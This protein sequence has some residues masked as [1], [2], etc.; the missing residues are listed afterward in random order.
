MSEAKRSN[1]NQSNPVT[2]V[3]VSVGPGIFALWNGI[4]N[5]GRCP[6]GFC[7]N[8]DTEGVRLKICWRNPRGFEPHSS[9]LALVVQW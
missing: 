7:N 2:R 1:P 5:E 6:S 8:A 3:Q 9:Q 4:S